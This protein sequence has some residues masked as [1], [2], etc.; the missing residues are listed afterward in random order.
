MTSAQHPLAEPTRQLH[1][2]PRGLVSEGSARAERLRTPPVDSTDP[3][4][5]SKPTLG[6]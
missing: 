3:K 4:P 1:G 6:R 2:P 5:G